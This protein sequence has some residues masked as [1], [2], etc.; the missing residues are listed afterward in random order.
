MKQEHQ[1]STLFHPTAYA[2]ALELTPRAKAMVMPIRLAI[3]DSLSRE[4][5]SRPISMLM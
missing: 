3:G 2:P 4:K 5:A 1:C